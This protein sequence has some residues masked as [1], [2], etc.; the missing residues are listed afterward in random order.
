MSEMLGPVLAGL[1]FIGV[2]SEGIYSATSMNNKLSSTDWG[3][4]IFIPTFIS[5]LLIT[6]G[7]YM[8]F[9]NNS[10]KTIDTGMFYPL[11]IFMASG[12]IAFSSIVI[13]FSQHVVNWRSG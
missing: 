9:I 4:R 13:V 11:I 3:L 10:T 1:G 12:S 6:L 8:I 2:V 7:M 5:L